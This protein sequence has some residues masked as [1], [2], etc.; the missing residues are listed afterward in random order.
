[1]IVVPE[2]DFSFTIVI[3]YAI[4]VISLLLILAFSIIFAIVFSFVVA[5]PLYKIAKMMSKA[6]NM[7]LAD[8]RP[9]CY[10]GILYEVFAS[11]F[12]FEKAI[13]F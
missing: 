4:C 11:C 3:G 9:V 8:I 7:K 5:I 13:V 2:A 12:F 6:K 10:V 1:M